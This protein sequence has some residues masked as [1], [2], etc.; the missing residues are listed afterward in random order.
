MGKDQQVVVYT[1]IPNERTSLLPVD[2]NN[3]TLELR[4]STNKRG[5]FNKYKHVNF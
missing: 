3:T 4:E 2:S 1:E 5:T